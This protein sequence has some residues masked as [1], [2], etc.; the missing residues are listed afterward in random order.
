MA[1]GGLG[2]EDSNPS[3][4]VKWWHGAG[5]LRPFKREKGWGGPT[6]GHR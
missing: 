2:D 4:G 5:S 6:R 3:P 1:I